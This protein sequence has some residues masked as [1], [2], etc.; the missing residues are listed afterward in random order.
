MFNLIKKSKRYACSFCL[1]STR[2][3]EPPTYCLGGSCSILLSYVD[4]FCSCVIYCIISLLIF[5]GVFGR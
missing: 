5:Q 3:F 4:V 1:A 2:G